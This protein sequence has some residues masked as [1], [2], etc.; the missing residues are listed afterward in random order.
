[1]STNKKPTA[2]TVGFGTVDNRRRAAAVVVDDDRPSR[3]ACQLD[4]LRQRA[5]VLRLT[6]SYADYCT[7]R[8]A[9]LLAQAAAY[10]AGE[11]SDAA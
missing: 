8:R 7:A 3:P 6:G 11:V 5:E 4:A 9:F 10:Q 2:A 1:M